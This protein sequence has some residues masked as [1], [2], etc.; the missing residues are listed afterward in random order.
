MFPNSFQL[1]TIV[2]NQQLVPVIKINGQ[3]VIQISDV[4]SKQTYASP[5]ERSEKIFKSL[6][7]LQQNK[8]NFNRIRI[9]R[10]KSDYVAYV[11]NIEVYRVTPSDIIGTDLTVYEMAA[12]WRN[13][14][15]EALKISNSGDALLGVDLD[16]SGIDG[17]PVPVIGI[18][19]V[20]SNSS[21]IVML[22]QLVIFILIQAVAIFLTF[23]YLKRRYE[24]NLSDVHDR[25]KQFQSAQVTHQNV[26]SKLE[27]QLV[28][29]NDQYQQS[30]SSN[31][32]IQ[33]LGGS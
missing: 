21:L 24:S 17:T 33:H 22:F 20:F 5:F 25:F 9:R 19:S 29:L 6:K 3:T 1:S 15:T 11:D 12:N 10:N 7:G 30:V 14:I 31:D 4:G 23:Q 26:I 13:N 2:D 16:K 28:E 27:N 32:N 8:D 18:L